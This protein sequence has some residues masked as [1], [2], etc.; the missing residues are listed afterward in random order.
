MEI[1]G[2]LVAVGLFVGTARL[3]VLWHGYRDARED[4]RR[5]ARYRHPS[6][7]GRGPEIEQIPPEE[8]RE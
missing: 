4:A 1:I 2:A 7:R 8:P 6:A 3:W 5:A